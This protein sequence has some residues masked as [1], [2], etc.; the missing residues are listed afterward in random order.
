MKNNILSKNYKKIVIYDEKTKKELAII[1]DEKVKTAS[2][3]IVVK[4]QP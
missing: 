1:T 4:L 2:S 3:N